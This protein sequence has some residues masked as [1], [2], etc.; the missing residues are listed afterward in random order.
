MYYNKGYWFYLTND[1]DV[2]FSVT[3]LQP[4]LPP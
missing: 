4:P 2:T 3:D 1:I